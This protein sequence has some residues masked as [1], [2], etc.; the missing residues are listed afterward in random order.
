MRTIHISGDL[1]DQF[2]LMKRI[3]KNALKEDNLFHFF[4]ET[5]ELIIRVS[6]K[7]YVDKVKNYLKLIKGITMTDYEYPFPG[8]GKYGEGKRSITV[9]YLWLFLPIYHT[10]SVA[11]LSMSRD[12]FI[13]F[14]T[15]ILHGGFNMVMMTQ[16]GELTWLNIYAA[17]KSRML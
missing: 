10:L 4:N 3:Y 16:F 6:D 17:R 13:D 11:A 15:K 1:G 8:K 14:T 5:T 9:K 7:L 12:T 2:R